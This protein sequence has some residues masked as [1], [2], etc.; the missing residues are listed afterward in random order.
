M[1]SDNILGSGA[2]DPNLRRWAYD[3]TTRVFQPG[4]ADF[5]ILLHSGNTDGWC[6]VV[7]LLCEPGDLILCEEHTYP[8]AQALWIPMGC[9]AVPIKMDSDGIEPESLEKMLA[10]WDTTHPFVKRPHLYVAKI[11]MAP[12]PNC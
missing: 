5:E 9:K 2:G 6:K 3:F 10:T 4:Y 12:N 11:V 1:C 8:S 7:R